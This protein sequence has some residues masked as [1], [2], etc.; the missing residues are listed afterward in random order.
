MFFD[1]KILYLL[2]HYGF[3]PFHRNNINDTIVTDS[4]MSKNTRDFFEKK[5][6][7]LDKENIQNNILLM[8][9]GNPDWLNELEIEMKYRYE[10]SL[11][12]DEEFRSRMSQYSDSDD[13]DYY[14][15]NYY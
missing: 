3:N 12:D 7:S 5:D 1:T 6:F 15:D 10:K 13:Y 14:S 11:K 9:R 8:I 2:I 4:V